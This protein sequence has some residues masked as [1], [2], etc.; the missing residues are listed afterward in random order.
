MVNNLKEELWLHNTKILSIQTLWPRIILFQYLKVVFQ[1]KQSSMVNKNLKKEDVL[2]TFLSLTIQF[3]DLYLYINMRRKRIRLKFHLKLYLTKVMDNLSYKGFM[4]ELQDLMQP[5][6]VVI[7]K[8]KCLLGQNILK[9]FTLEVKLIHSLH[10][11]FMLRIKN[12]K[13]SLMSV[14]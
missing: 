10:E 9:F 6:L 3:W 2:I 11:N 5:N 8:L 4:I 7:D 12:P 14:V 13:G 1:I